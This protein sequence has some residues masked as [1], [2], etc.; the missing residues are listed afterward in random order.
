MLKMPKNAPLII[1]NF[2]FEKLRAKKSGVFTYIAI[3][4][5]YDGE[6]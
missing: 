3:P 4:F 6:V 5:E 1:E 2:Y